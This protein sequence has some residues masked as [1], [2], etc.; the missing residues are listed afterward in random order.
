MVRALRTP[1]GL[2]QPLA[3]MVLPGH[4]PATHSAAYRAGVAQYRCICGAKT[5]PAPPTTAAALWREHL[6]MN[7]SKT[8]KLVASSEPFQFA[9]RSILEIIWEEMDAV[10]GRLMA[11]DGAKAKGDKGRAAGLAYAI[12][13]IQNPYEVNVEAVRDQAHA[14][15]EAGLDEEDIE[16]INAAS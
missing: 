3:A 16:R 13:V 6:E 7:M 10:Y 15:W 5:M 8:E 14:R 1:V 11:G 4:R 2:P 9:G 12:A